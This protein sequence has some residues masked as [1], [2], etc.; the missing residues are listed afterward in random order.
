MTNIVSGLI[1]KRAEMAGEGV[2]AVC[3]RQVLRQLQKRKEAQNPRLSTQVARNEG[4]A[5]FQVLVSS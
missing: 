3:H 5:L 2:G 4:Q 1:A